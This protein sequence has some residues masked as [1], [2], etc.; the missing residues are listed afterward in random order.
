MDELFWNYF[1]V[2]FLQNNYFGTILEVWNYLELFW[3]YFGGD[4]CVGNLESCHL[5]HLDLAGGVVT[6]EGGVDP[7]PGPGV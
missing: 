7:G 1:G 5:C 2:Q 6:V 3:N 4:P